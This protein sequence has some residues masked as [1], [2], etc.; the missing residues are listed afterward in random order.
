MEK[1]KEN[2][3]A[4]FMAMIEQSW[5]WDRL[6][7]LERKNFVNEI[8]SGRAAATALRGDYK[9]R[10]NICNALYSMYLEGVGYSG[11]GWREPDA[12]AVPRF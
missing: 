5:T 1:N 8:Y 12:D 11:V 9:H 2:A 7:E 3:V 6:T 10:W 4:D